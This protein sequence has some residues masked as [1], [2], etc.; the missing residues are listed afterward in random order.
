MRKRNNERLNRD[1]AIELVVN[2]KYC[3]EFAAGFCG[4]ME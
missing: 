2:A 4:G 3:V 1:L